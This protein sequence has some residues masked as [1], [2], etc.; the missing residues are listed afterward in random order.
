MKIHYLEQ[1]AHK[2]AFTK[3]GTFYWELFL[4]EENIYNA[5]HKYPYERGW[6]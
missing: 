5:K 4:V 3:L 1:Q 2:Y 6:K